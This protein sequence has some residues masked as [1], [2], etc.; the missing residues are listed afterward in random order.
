MDFDD[1]NVKITLA[2][3]KL[4]FHTS[5]KNIGFKVNVIEWLMFNS[6]KSGVM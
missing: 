1:L 4:V 6:S 2:L 5:V 3:I